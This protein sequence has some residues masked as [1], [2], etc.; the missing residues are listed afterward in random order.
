MFEINSETTFRSKLIERIGESGGLCSADYY[1]FE[2]YLTKSFQVP[3]SPSHFGNPALCAKMACR[4]LEVTRP[5]LDGHREE[6]G[7]VRATFSSPR[8]S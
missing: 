7:K 2:D 6:V 5:R 8:I 4:H 1:T 3:P